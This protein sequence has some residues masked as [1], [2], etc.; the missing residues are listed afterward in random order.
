VK[1]GMLQLVAAT[2]GRQQQQPTTNERLL[3]ARARVP[4]EAERH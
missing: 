1:G 3:A 4:H 2:P